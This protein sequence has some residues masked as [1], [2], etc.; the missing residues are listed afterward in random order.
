MRTHFNPLVQ[1]GISLV[2]VAL[3]VFIVAFTLPQSAQ[4]SSILTFHC[5]VDSIMVTSGGTTLLQ[6]SRQQLTTP[7][8]T[9]ILSGY[10]QWIA[11]A[12]GVSLWALTSNELQ[13]HWDYD[14]D[15]TKVI[16]S[17]DSCGQGTTSAGFQFSCTGYGLRVSSWQSELMTLSFDQLAGP[18]YTAILSNQNQF[19][20][21]SSGASLWA[22]KSNEFQVHW[23]N[24]PNTSKVVVDATLCGVIPAQVLSGQP[25]T[26]PTNPAGPTYPTYPTSPTGTT[27][28]TTYVV[29][30]G[31]NLYRISLRFGRTVAQIAQANGI[32]NYDLIYAGQTL[33]IP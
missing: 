30:H 4:A 28:T 19:I 11:S 14:P 22:L 10:N 20:A 7:L 18:L 6:V 17:P 26:Y 5:S 27:Y 32:T 21:S 2:S 3:I 12:N 1:A 29:Q 25:T 33:I 16:V 9:A 31:D 15:G 24:Q 13:A 23:D 8:H